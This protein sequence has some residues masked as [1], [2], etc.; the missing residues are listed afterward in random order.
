VRAPRQDRSSG[1]RV[2]I[3]TSGS[4]SERVLVGYGLDY[5]GLYRNLPYVA[6]LDGI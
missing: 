5:D 1:D 6:T 2:T 4:R 3:D